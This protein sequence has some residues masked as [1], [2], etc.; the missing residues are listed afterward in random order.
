VTVQDY[1]P[2]IFYPSRSTKPGLY[3]VFAE[4][5]EKQHIPFLSYMPSEAYLI[6]H[7]YNVIIDALLGCG[8]KGSYPDAD[9]AAVIQTIIKSEVPVVSL[10]LP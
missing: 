5:C 4:Q 2:T 10:D 6:G 1:R 7:A 3:A 8:F 9:M